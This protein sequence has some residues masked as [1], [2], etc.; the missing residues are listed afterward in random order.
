MV[1]DSYRADIRGAAGLGIPAVLVHRHHP[2]AKHYAE[3]LT[4]V[5]ALLA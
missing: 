4:E 5:P 2:D 1:G 3:T